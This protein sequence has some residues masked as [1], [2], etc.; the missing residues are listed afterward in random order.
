MSRREF[1]IEKRKERA[2]RGH[3][4]IKNSGTEP[5]FSQK[6]LK[7]IYLQMDISNRPLKMLN[8]Y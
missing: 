4:E 1:E 7:T 2:K 8:R 6:R 3:F 5:I